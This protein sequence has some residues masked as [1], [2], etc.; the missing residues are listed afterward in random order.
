MLDMTEMLPTVLAI[1]SNYPAIARFH[2]E[3]YLVVQKQS[4]NCTHTQVGIHT[5]SSFDQLGLSHAKVSK[6]N[7]VNSVE[8]SFRVFGSQFLNLFPCITRIW[9]F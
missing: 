8:V 6:V 3:S 7:V 9:F 1:G 5:T 4:G 2:Q